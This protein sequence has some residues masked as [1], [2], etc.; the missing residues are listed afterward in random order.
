MKRY[1]LNVLLSLL[2]MVS[3]DGYAQQPDQQ[4]TKFAIASFGQD[5]FDQTA[6]N[7]QFEKIDGNGARYAIIKVTSTNPEDD[8]RAYQFN[9]GNLNSLVEEHDGQ[10]WVYVQRNAKLVTISREGYQTIDKH[11]LG[12]TIDAGKTYI[13]SLASAGII[14]PNQMVMFN[15]SPANSNAKIIIKNDKPGAVEE[16]FGTINTTGMIGKSIPMGAYTYRV[17]ASGYSVSEGR[18]TL[19][20]KSSI[21]IEPVTLVQ[22]G[23][24]SVTSQ[25]EGAKLYLNGKYQGTT[26]YKA[27]QRSG[28]YKL[29]LKYSDIK[30]KY[31]Y[32]SLKGDFH[33]NV[34]ENKELSYTMNKKIYLKSTTGY[35]FAPFFIGSNNILGV[36]AGIGVYIHNFNIEVNIPWHFWWSY[37]C[38]DNN[39]NYVE[40][41]NE[42]GFPGIDVKAGYGFILWH[43]FRITPQIGYSLVRAHYGHYNYVQQSDN[44]W[45]YTSDGNLYPIHAF[46]FGA[47]MEF[48]IVR[49][50]GFFLTPIAQFRIKNNNL[51][52]NTNEVSL[53]TGSYT[54]SRSNL[55]PQKLKKMGQG[56]YVQMGLYF[57]L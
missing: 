35:V 14:I 9:F 23:V 1:L 49:H 52:Q 48:A 18:I 29:K 44:S 46:T 30:N 13:M 43:H 28:D 26:P 11:D 51:L 42:Y 3:I 20:D 27:P 31:K 32:K 41:R 16:E 10:L 17:V 22:L 37:E 25:P 45:N 36:N 38:P 5:P 2:A 19:K 57:S 15:V 39:S 55:T 53:M 54:N 8:L 4:K 7:P 33:M 40:L 6:T 47:R 12:L 21:H 34:D 50:M 24:L 56:F